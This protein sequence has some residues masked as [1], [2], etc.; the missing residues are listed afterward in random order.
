ME[1]L[2]REPAIADENPTR[3]G[4]LLIKLALECMQLCCS[5][6]ISDPFGLNQIRFVSELK[7]TV[8][9]LAN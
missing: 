3:P 4:S 8:Y 1:A 5:N 9:L 2:L 7:T 6:W